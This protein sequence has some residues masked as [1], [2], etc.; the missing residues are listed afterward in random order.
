MNDQLYDL[1]VSFAGEQRDYVS[2]AVA[3]CKAFGLDVFYDADKNNDWWGGNFIREQRQVYM[4]KTRFFV[5]FISN[6]YLSKPYPMDEFSAAMLT[7]V[8]QGDGYILPVIIGNPDIPP[9]LLHP[10]IGYLRAEDYTPVQL[11]QELRR[12]VSGAKQAGQAPAGIGQVVENALGVRLPKIVPASFSK[13]EELDRIFEYLS[14]RFKEGAEQLEP[15]GLKCHIRSRDESLVIRIE[16]NGDTVAGLNLQ[17]GGQMGDDHITW[18]AGRQHIGN[19]FNGWATP[20]F[21]KERGEA[22]VD[23]NDMASM[24]TGRDQPDG[25]Y[26]GFFS[27]LCDKL[28]VQVET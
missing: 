13:F 15:H 3:A 5:P 26:E 9:D 1:A 17:K 7:A 11:A 19:G 28:M 25:T 21:D 24:T 8:K 27:L 22:V 20:K 10:H 16:R 6:E 14:R 2:A 23:V 18:A 4:S 12:K